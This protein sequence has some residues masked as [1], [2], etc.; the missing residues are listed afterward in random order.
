MLLRGEP[1]ES[2]SDGVLEIAMGAGIAVDV[3]DCDVMVVVVGRRGR[4]APIRD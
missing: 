4:E 2:T 1:N 3:V